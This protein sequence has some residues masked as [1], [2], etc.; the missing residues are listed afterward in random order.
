MSSFG[1]MFLSGVIWIAIFLLAAFFGGR[2]GG[3][4]GNVL[5]YGGSAMAGLAIWHLVRMTSLQVR[6]RRMAKADPEGY[7]QLR[8]DYEDAMQ[9]AREREIANSSEVDS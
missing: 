1:G 8:K 9:R 6:S 2:L 7:A 4:F 3:F 5:L